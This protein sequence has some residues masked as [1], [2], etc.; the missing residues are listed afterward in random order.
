MYYAPISLASVIPTMTN[1]YSAWLFMDGNSNIIGSS[2]TNL[3]PFYRITSMPLPLLL[4]DLLVKT[5]HTLSGSRGIWVIF[6]KK[7]L[8]TWAFKVFLASK[9]IS[10]L[11]NSMVHFV[12][13]PARPG[14][15][16]T[17]FRGKS[18]LTTMECARRYCRS[19]R[20][21]ITN[22]RV[23][24]SIFFYRTSAPYGTFKIKYTNL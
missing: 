1:L 7:S 18:F 3:E 23:A 4:D 11:D 21:A 19:F 15:Q 13:L 22:T 20:D 16:S 9:N 10:N 5:T 14:L 8:N 24:F 12:N 6:A 17:C 2:T